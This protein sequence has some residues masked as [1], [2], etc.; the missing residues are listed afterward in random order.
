[1]RERLPHSAT[2]RDAAPPDSPGIDVAA[3][4]SS[5]REAYQILSN[6]RRRRSYDDRLPAERARLR[7]VRERLDW[8][9]DEVAI[10]FP[11]ILGPLARMREAFLAPD[12]WPHPLAAEIQLSPREAFDGVVIPVNV[13]V[14]RTCTECGGRGEIWTEPCTGCDGSG[15]ALAHHPIQLVVPPRVADGVRFS[16]C[17]S[18]PSAPPTRVEVRISIR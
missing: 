1:M 18:A 14:R 5:V 8:F 9:A 17:V 3:T 10:D 7:A 13:P 12:E 2:G 15:D 4:F 11:S 16:L 6:D